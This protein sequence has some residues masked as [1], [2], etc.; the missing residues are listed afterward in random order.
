[1]HRIFTIPF[2]LAPLLASAAG[3]DEPPDCDGIQSEGAICTGR[4][5]TAEFTQADKSLNEAYQ[6]L[7]AQLKLDGRTLSIKRLTTAQRDWVRFR[8][9]NCES[10]ADFGGGVQMWQSVRWV[11]CRAAMS[12]DR[13]KE[14]Q[15]SYPVGNGGYER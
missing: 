2:L 7:L 15:E 14:L 4:A 11:Q 8:D 3:P 13:V 1:M 10:R 5:A 6:K 12:R 9:S